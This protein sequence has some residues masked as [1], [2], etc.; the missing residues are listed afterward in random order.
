M[1]EQ[2]EGESSCH[3]TEIRV[4]FRV[5]TEIERSL[6]KDSNESSH[7]EDPIEEDKIYSKFEEFHQKL[8]IFPPDK[9]SSIDNRYD[10]C[11]LNRVFV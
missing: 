1:Y 3:C 9:R 11:I 5:Q 8:Y 2:T 6:S 4:K 10:T 7:N